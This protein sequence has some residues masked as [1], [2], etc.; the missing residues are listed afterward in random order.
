MSALVSLEVDRDKRVATIRL[1]RPPMNAIGAELLADLAGVVADVAVDET[2]RAVVVWGGPKIFAAGAD[3][4][5][6]PELDRDGGAELG[7][8]LN[9]AFSALE[10]LPQVTIAAVNGYALGGGCELAMATDFRFAGDD[11]V[12]GQPEIL[13][14]LI[15]GAGGTQRLTR[16]V[17]VTKA[18][19]LIYSG[20][21]VRADEAVSIGLASSVHPAAQLYDDA[22]EAAATYARGPAALTMAKRAILDGLALPMD[23]AIA[24]ETERFAD[25]FATADFATGVTSFVEEGPGKA[26]FEGR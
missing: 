19:E 24:V 6:F 3:I 4:T 9:A 26:V 20:R 22:V 8:R 16:L 15:P 17:G 21:Q 12:F 11:A 18:K 13:L 1:D 2:V 23:E 5:E 14:G 7:G 10:N 25:C